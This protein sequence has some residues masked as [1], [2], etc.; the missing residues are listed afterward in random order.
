MSDKYAN[1][2]GIIWCWHTHKRPSGSGEDAHVICSFAKR[3]WGWSCQFI[4]CINLKLPSIYFHGFSNIKRAIWMWSWIYVSER[5]VS[6]GKSFCIA[7]ECYIKLKA[8]VLS[9][10]EWSEFRNHPNSLHGR[11]VMNFCWEAF[12]A[13]RK[14]DTSLMCATQWILVCVFA[15]LYLWLTRQR[16]VVECQEEKNCKP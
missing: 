8:C 15:S 11:Q 2:F 13:L 14:I 9:L 3:W 4:L 16:I 6:W 5:R 7:E 1:P 12:R 10:R